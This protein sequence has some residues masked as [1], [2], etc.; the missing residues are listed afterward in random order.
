MFKAGGRH[1]GIGTY[2]HHR[3]DTSIPAW[4]VRG[5]ENHRNAPAYN[6]A[7]VA[8]REQEGLGE[9]GIDV[10]GSWY[11]QSQDGCYCMHGTNAPF[12]LRR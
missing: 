11:E 1:K 10:M 5:H 3:H 8:R 7:W 4:S 12:H 6:V 2:L 9:A